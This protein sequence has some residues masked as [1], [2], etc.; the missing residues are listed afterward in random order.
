VDGN[1][2]AFDAFDRMA[3]KVDQMEAQAEAARELE[4]LSN[5]SSLERRFSELERSTSS[6]DLLLEDLKKK[7]NV[8]PDKT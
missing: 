4:D 7:M 1:R 3:Q 5:N 8:L 2:S 6:A